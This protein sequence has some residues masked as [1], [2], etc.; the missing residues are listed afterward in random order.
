MIRAYVVD[1]ILNAPSWLSGVLYYHG[2]KPACAQQGPLWGVAL[3]AAER[4]KEGPG[5]CAHSNFMTK[6]TFFSKLQTEAL[7]AHIL[8]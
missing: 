8:H 3:K 5:S 4:K 1:V 6:S 7:R 2:Y